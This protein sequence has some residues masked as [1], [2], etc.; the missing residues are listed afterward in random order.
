MNVALLATRSRRSGG[1]PWAGAPEVC[2]AHTPFWKV[3]AT[4]SEAEGGQGGQ[5]VGAPQPPIL[6]GE[7]FSQTL[8]CELNWRSALQ[9]KVSCKQI[10]L[11]HRKTGCLSVRCLCSALLTGV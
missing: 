7:Y 1:N 4:W 9:A 8:G 11:F 2:S 3:P 6:F 10:G 5:E